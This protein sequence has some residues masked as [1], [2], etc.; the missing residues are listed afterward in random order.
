MGSLAAPL[1]EHS[2]TPLGT[3]G[4]HNSPSEVLFKDLPPILISHPFHVLTAPGSESSALTFLPGDLP[5][6]LL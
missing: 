5:H 1:P 2:A 3:E 6:I 4:L